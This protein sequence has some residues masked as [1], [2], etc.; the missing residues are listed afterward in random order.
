MSLLILKEFFAVGHVG[1]VV[2]SGVRVWILTS[3]Q[4]EVEPKV[5]PAVPYTPMVELG[6]P[7]GALELVG[8]PGIKRVVL[9]GHREDALL[10]VHRIKFLFFWRP[11]LA[12]SSHTSIF[13]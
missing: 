11:S 4:V 8:L 2:L 13:S 1:G 6:E 7:Q 10:A 3:R 9:L 12:R 5:K